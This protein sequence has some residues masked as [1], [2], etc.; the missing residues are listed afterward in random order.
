MGQLVIAP[1]KFEGINVDAKE[2]LINQEVPPGISLI[3]A[4]EIWEQGQYGKGIVIAVLDS[5]CDENHPDLQGQIIE[6]R[7]FTDIGNYNEYFDDHGHG[8]H[9]SGT[10]AAKRDGKGV[11]GVAPEA[12]LL[13]LKVLKKNPDNPKEAIG[14]TDWTA[15]AIDYAI[16]WRGPNGERVRIISMSLVGRQGDFSYH[17]SIRKAVK[18][19]VLVV[20]CAGNYGDKDEGGDCSPEHDEYSYPGFYSEVISVGAIALDKTFPCFTVTNSQVDLVAP[21]VEIISTTPNGGYGIGTGTSMA[22]PHVSGA[23]ALLINKCVKDFGRS[24]TEN[25]IYAQVVK[26][27]VSLGESKKRE[28]NGLLDLTIV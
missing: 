3:H 19:D 6:G 15:T 20:A 12:K 27:T 11:V 28:G 13:I 16:S 10:I 23:L 21:G 24:L 17:E 4:P 8:T 18:N 2:T 14:N 22:V 26:R 25:E 7:N 5:G 9:V 1:T